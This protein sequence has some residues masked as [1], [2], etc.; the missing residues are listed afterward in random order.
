MEMSFGTLN[1]TKSKS[2]MAVDDSAYHPVLLDPHLL[3]LGKQNFL[4]C[5]SAVNLH[6]NMH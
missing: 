3:K 2:C 4:I 5:Q 1:G 6:I